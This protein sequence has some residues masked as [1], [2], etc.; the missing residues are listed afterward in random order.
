MQPQKQKMETIN[1]TID[2]FPSYILYAGSG[3]GLPPKAGLGWVDKDISINKGRPIFNFGY[4]NTI[5]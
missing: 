3:S 5:N 4:F 2:R 1:E